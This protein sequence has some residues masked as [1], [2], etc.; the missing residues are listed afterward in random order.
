MDSFEDVK[1]RLNECEHLETGET[2]L[3]IYIAFCQITVVYHIYHNQLV[4]VS[5]IVEL[6]ESCFH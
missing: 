1:L 6:I 3:T 4:K 5:K 2:Y